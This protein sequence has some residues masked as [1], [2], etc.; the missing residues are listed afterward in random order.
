MKK[1][2]LHI[3]LLILGAAL[4]AF[5]FIC[6]KEDASRKLNGACIGIGAGLIGLS[7]ANL[8][9]LGWFQRHPDGKRQAEI[10][11][12]DERNQSIRYKA[13]AK[14]SDVIKWIIMAFAWITIFTDLPLWITLT[15]IGIFVFKEIFELFLMN[16]YNKEM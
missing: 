11:S 15:L 12:K 6:L 5:S 1:K 13:K 8:T 4:L 9:I 3:A 14:S 10:D 2:W 7:F 16:R